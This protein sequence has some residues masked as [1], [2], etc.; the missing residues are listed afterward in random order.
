[1][2]KALTHLSLIFLLATTFSPYLLYA[3]L[4]S[5]KM[6]LQESNGEN[7]VNILNELYRETR[8]GEPEKALGYAQEAL[9]LA[10]E[11]DYK[12]GAA[13]AL[14]NIG[15]YHRYKGNYELAIDYYVRALRIHEEIG[16]EDGVALTLGNIGT[17]YSLKR[18]FDKSLEYYN[19][20]LALLE[21]KGDKSRV[22]SIYNNIGNVYFDLGD[23]LL[24]ADYY[25]RA[26]DLQEKLGFQ[27]RG[28]DLLTSMGNI[29]LRQRDYEKALTYFT[30]SLETEESNGN[31]YGQAV[32]YNNIGA[33]HK[34]MG[35]YAKALNN[36]YLARALALDVG[37]KPLL[38]IIYKNLSETFYYKKD[39]EKSLEYLEQFILL[40]DKLY[41]EESSRK[42]AELESSYEVAKKEKEIELLRKESEI[43]DLQVR[44]SNLF[45]SIFI[46][47][48]ALLLVL[49]ILYYLK[50]AHNQR[51]K[52]LFEERN[53][54]VTRRNKEIEK[55]KAIIEYKNQNITDS[56]QYA[57]SIQETIL[58]KDIF[59]HN[60]PDSFIFYKPKD[61]VSGDFFWYARKDG[62][63]I[64]A[65][66]DCT[67]HGVA[68][69]FMTV[70]GNS[71]LNQIINENHIYNPAEIL[72][73]LDDKL[74]ETLKQQDEG[75]TNYGMDLAI[76]KI[77]R[78]NR[79]VVFSGA[80][81]P[82]Y[83]VHDGQLRDYKG[84]NMSIGDM[85]GREKHFSEHEINYMPGDIFYLFSDGF[86]DQ[87]GVSV[88]KKYMSKR[89]RLLIQ[90]IQKQSMEKQG[91]S[92][93]LEMNRW[94]GQN[95]QTDD[96]LV[97][98]FRL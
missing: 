90:T 3:Q 22:I 32:A 93:E 2:K 59:K 39:Y 13:N 74:T 14:N 6:A 34:L 25:L 71:L 27:N 92:L 43:K 26:I 98:G 84:D 48:G 52:I 30:E 20:A 12:R 36:Q 70:I 68:G 46:M 78:S 35:D 38:T 58:K 37:N 89:F 87:F 66:I 62:F 60:L 76:C 49:L 75:N 33:A 96:M 41:N 55:Q 69:A 83:F 86:A 24:A 81:R 15:V 54:E 53:K 16:N 67:G 61:I 42:L 5:L 95:E 23:D 79:K 65:L 56:I 50:F 1:M 17:L 51:V 11:I 9:K 21:K 82:L 29:Y 85:S 77:D 31:K 57:K 73:E 72:F 10:T 63:D 88:D 47:A 28:F 94:M 19:K 91:Q 64:V 44:N 80:K 40:K 4:D 18:D 8:N 7:K 45:T 97:L